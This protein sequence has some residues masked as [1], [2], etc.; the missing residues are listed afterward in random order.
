MRLPKRK[1][2][3]KFSK[4]NTLEEGLILLKEAYQISNNVDGLS[5]VFDTT[6]EI[7]ISHLINL[8]I[9]N[10]KFCYHC[11]NE[12]GCW[13]DISEF[14]VDNSK[15]NGLKS[16]CKDCCKLQVHNW[17]NENV[18]HVKNY[19]ENYSSKNKDKI[20]IQQQVWY[21]NT[22][23]IRQ[24]ISSDYYHANK[25]ERK[26]YQ[27]DRFKEEHNLVKRRALQKLYN[28]IRYKN[29]ISYRFR[30]M[31]SS[32]V[33]QILNRNNSSKMGESISDY[34]PYTMK[35]LIE[36]LESKFLPGMT[37]ENHGI[38]GWHIDHI[39]PIT[40]FNITSMDCQDFQECWALSN[41]QPLWWQDN[42][43]K[44]DSYNE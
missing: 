7:L 13:K 22:K 29:D 1:L 44:G 39:K 38:F 14:G 32:R 5:E 17:Y 21:Q 33:N 31:F 25:E 35:D 28:N 26:Q 42:L 15:P 10:K 9:Y 43:A 6:N 2:R 3:D 18:E 41:L 27:K 37:L 40:L 8:N 34:L 19:N 12:Q 16:Q 24:K 4:I 20:K 30:T 23:P 11:N 36:H